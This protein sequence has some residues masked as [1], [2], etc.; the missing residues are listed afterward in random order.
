MSSPSIIQSTN[1]I[2]KKSKNPEDTQKNLD[3]LTQKIASGSSVG[4]KEGGLLTKPK[5][6]RK[7]RKPSGKG[8]GNK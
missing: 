5:P 7:S 4:F 2:I 3:E 1:E 6:K 8:L